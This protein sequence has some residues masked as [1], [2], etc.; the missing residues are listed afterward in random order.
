MDTSDYTQELLDSMTEEERLHSI[1]MIRQLYDDFTREQLT[2]IKIK[3]YNQFSENLILDLTYPKGHKKTGEPLNKV[4]IIGQSATGKTTILNF[5][6]DFIGDKLNNEIE[7]SK[8]VTD[9]QAKPKLINF[10]AFGVEN[11]KQLDKDEI[12]EYEEQGYNE[13]IDFSK[14]DPKEHWYSIL[15][16]LKKYQEKAIDF[17]LEISENFKN[18]R[19]IKDTKTEIDKINKKIEVWENKN[20]NLLADLDFFLKPILRKFYLRIKTNP[21]SV[22][23]LKFIPVENYKYKTDGEISSKEIPTEFLSTGTKQILAR[24]IPLYSIKPENSIILIDEPEN[25]FY[26][27]VQKQYVDFIIESYP[28]NQFFFATHSPTIASSFEPWEIVELKFNENG[29]V[30]QR[31]YYEGERHVDNYFIHPKYMRW[32]DV[33]I[34]LFNSKF[35]GDEERNNALQEL[36]ILER[37]LEIDDFNEE[38]KK[39]M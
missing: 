16:D 38:E 10:P 12:L 15:Q 31:L 5:I 7:I 20:P 39:K 37:D 22:E 9:K 2:Q 26:P 32:D 14:T 25:S 24:S 11:I 3:N 17:N 13:I 29:K 36:S 30:E 21:S 28:N 4:C 19:N 33:L 23:D 35:E 6:K 8:K 18:L 34:E 27:D 1:E